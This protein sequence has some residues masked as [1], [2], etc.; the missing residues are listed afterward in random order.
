MNFGLGVYPDIESP[1]F[2]EQI[3]RKKEF[4]DNKLDSDT[5][6]FSCLLKYQKFLRNFMSILTNYNGLLINHYTG[7]GKTLSAIS[8]AEGLKSRYTTII[9]SKNDI[10]LN[11]F[12]QEITGKCTNYISTE[13]LNILNDP[14]VYPEEKTKIYKEI[15]KEVNKNYSF[16]KYTDIKSETRLNNK[17]V[18]IDEVHNITGNS[19]YT[20]ILECLKNSKNIKIVLLSATPTFDKCFEIFYIINL[21]NVVDNKPLLPNK[22]SEMTKAGFIKNTKLNV[23]NTEFI[24]KTESLYELTELGE[25]IIKQTTKGKVS[26]LLPDQQHFAKKKFN[27]QNVIENNVNSFVVYKSHMSEFQKSIYNIKLKDPGVLY[28]NA[29]DA[30]TMV[31]PDQSIGEKGF[32]NFIKDQ[33]KKN[34]DFLNIQNIKKYSCKLYNLIKIIKESDG[35]IFIF[36]NYVNNGGTNLIRQVLIENGYTNYFSRNDKPKYYFFN[37][38]TSVNVKNKISKILNDPN[39]KDGSK[40]KIIIGSPFISEGITFKNIR[41]IHILEPYWNFSRIDQVIGRGI[42]FKSHEAL[43]KK[44]QLVDI[45]LHVSVGDNVENSIDIYKYK[46]CQFKDIH[47]KKVEYILKKNSIDCFFNKERNMLKNVFDYTRECQYKKCEYICPFEIE[48]KDNNIDESSFQ[49]ELHDT[50]ALNYIKKNIKDIFKEIN[51]CDINYI[52]KYIKDNEDSNY[53][54]NS[55]NKKNIYYV[56]DK[57]IE[58]SE[59]FLNN[60]NIE[61]YLLKINKYYIS[62]PKDNPISE[63]FYNKLFVK[64]N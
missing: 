26:F 10:L 7:L 16:F 34:K 5:D 1:D 63:S 18:I 25:E 12:K 37:E 56:L 47:N 28:K 49:I 8:I 15:N 62:N 27:G 48:A 57:I 42:R 3:T 9:I 29:S 41:Q 43:V 40:L 2:Y 6:G 11:N 30:S 50:D 59:I 14:N 20:N 51:V 61:C 32:V 22:I 36:S 45:Y 60:K 58:D 24:T 13:Q 44:D 31:Y 33:N 17:L 55:I 19:F 21:L 46:I 39:N 4:L 53:S 52:I 35:I 64:Q 38:S 54:K 23:K